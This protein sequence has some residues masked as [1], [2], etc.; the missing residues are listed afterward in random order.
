MSELLRLWA[1]IECGRSRPN[2]DAA[3]ALW[4]TIRTRDDGREEPTDADLDA[5]DALEAQRAIDDGEVVQSLPWERAWT[6]ADAAL[7]GAR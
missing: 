1:A 3:D 6:T 4:R 5:A 7:R 2:Q